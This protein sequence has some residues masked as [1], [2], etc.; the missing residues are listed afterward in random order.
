MQYHSLKS[1]TI[2]RVPNTMSRKRTTPPKP[3]VFCLEGIHGVGKTTVFEILSKNRGSSKYKFY[4]ERLVSNPLFPFGSHDKQIAFRAENHFMQQMIQRNRM[5]IDD[6][7]K[8][9]VEFAILDRSAISVMV[10]SKA[11]DLPQK[12]FKLLDDYYNSVNW[13]ENILFYL[14]ATPEIILDRIIKR[15]MIDVQRL[16]WNEDDLN[17]IRSLE[18]YYQ[19][20]LSKLKNKI[21][22]IEVKTDDLKP[23]EV[24]DIIQSNIEIYRTRNQ[25]SPNQ[26]SID[27]WLK[28]K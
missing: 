15:G 9:R 16:E 5:I 18:R 11:L 22:I 6:I 27:N 19:Y 14:R 3:Y 10:Y 7:S 24:A 17:Y 26:E 8:K 4:P 1:H 23:I 25:K 28:N 12:D 2:V 21:I 20:Y 13:A